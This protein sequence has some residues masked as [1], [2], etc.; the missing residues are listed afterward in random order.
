MLDSLNRSIATRGSWRK[1]TQ[2][3]LI[4]WRVVNRVELRVLLFVE[5]STAD[6]FVVMKLKAEKGEYVWDAFF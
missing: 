1:N 6:E 4:S 5:S 2:R 3:D